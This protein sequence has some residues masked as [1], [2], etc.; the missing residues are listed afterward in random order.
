[1]A[2]AKN[3]MTPSGI[4][5][6]DFYLRLATKLEQQTKTK[7]PKQPSMYMFVALE[8]GDVLI[9]NREARQA[10]EH[11]VISLLP[12]PGRPICGGHKI[13][14]LV[15]LHQLANKWMQYPADRGMEPK[16]PLNVAARGL[17]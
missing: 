17:S 7:R 12:K 11:H 15:V 10:L 5:K 8:A 9:D 13:N 2:V 3:W 1:M 6:L 4:Q 14:D 16:A